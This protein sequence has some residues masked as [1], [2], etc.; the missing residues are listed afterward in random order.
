MDKSTTRVQTLKDRIA[1][2][3][4]DDGG[5]PALA[6][7]L[8][9]SADRPAKQ[10][11]LQE[12]LETQMPRC[13]VF[14]NDR[15]ETLALQV[16]SGRIVAVTQPT[17]PRLMGTDLGVLDQAI[18]DNDGPT[19]SVVCR[20]FRI[21]LRHARDLHVA[22]DFLKKRSP[23]AT[24]IGL[25]TRTL[26]EDM[27]D[28]SEVIGSTNVLLSFD[29][30]AVACAADATAMLRIDG[31]EVTRMKGTENQTN[32]LLKLAESEFAPRTEATRLDN[33]QSA[34]DSCVIVCGPIDK[35]Q[36]VLSCAS[37]GLMVY[38]L[39]ESMKVGKML[40]LWLSR[41]DY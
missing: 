30:F 15:D 13:L 38:V 40:A 20:A 28:E 8:P 12:I 39:F 23:S 21:F 22:I 27:D 33:G 31:T 29:R 10:V 17:S 7:K 36:A 19:I 35:A 9:F 16:I 14:R 18:S 25:S 3:A 24:N 1:A 5:A 34:L 2:L 41:E 26:F 11:M 4:V 6:R 32:A 37:N